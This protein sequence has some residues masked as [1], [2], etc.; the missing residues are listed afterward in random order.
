MKLLFYTVLGI[1][2]TSA[3]QQKTEGDA[4]GSKTKSA[5]EAGTKTKVNFN[6]LDGLNISADYYAA[7]N[8]DKV[9]ILCHQAG[10]SRGAYRDIAPRL[11]DAGFDCMAV[12]L[13]SGNIANE[14]I[15]ETHIEAVKNE[16][17]TDYQDA[18]QD[19]KAAINYV[20]E[21]TGKKVVLWGSSYSATLV[22]VE[23]RDNPNVV[24]VVAI[25]P[26]IY[27]SSEST[28]RNAVVGYSKPV[29]VT[30]SR[31]EEA[32]AKQLVLAIQEPYLN[33]ELPELE[34]DHGSKMF[35]VQNEQINAL[36]QKIIDFI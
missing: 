28:L 6:S 11:V 18:A 25:S 5:F 2:M 7:E 30:C 31:S 33:F 21:K 8:S 17:G 3:C 9:V 16:V 24:K 34:G 20:K 13:R 10:F 23:G 29:F 26:G 22:L 15:N 1:L 32:I 19:I 14:V 36:F 12:D 27:F 35:W 4:N